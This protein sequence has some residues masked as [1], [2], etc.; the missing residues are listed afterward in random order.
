MVTLDLEQGFHH[1]PIHKKLY[2]NLCFHWKNEYFN[3]ISTTFG[4]NFSNFFVKR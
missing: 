2:N 1:I 4:G 3:W